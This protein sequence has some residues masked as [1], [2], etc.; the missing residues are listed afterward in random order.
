MH[1]LFILMHETK[2]YWSRRVGLSALVYARF[3]WGPRRELLCYVIK[4]NLNHHRS[5]AKYAMK[6]TDTSLSFAGM[7]ILELSS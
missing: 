4:L 7:M 5:K 3:K 1:M 6:S 2:K